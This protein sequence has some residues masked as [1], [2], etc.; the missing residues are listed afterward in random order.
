[1]DDLNVILAATGIIVNTVGLAF[2]AVQVALARRQISES[3]KIASNEHSRLRRQGTV[4]FYMATV[5]HRSRWRAILPEDWN[6]QAITVFLADAFEPG[7]QAK[8]DALTDYFGYLEGLAVAVAAG[9]YDLDT[10]DAVFGDR[11]MAVARNYRPF[12]EESRLRRG[13][14]ALYVEFEWLADK[15]RTLR[16]G[17][18][19]YVLYADRPHQAEPSATRTQLTT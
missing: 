14:P 9:V 11:L 8:L 15:L 4:D 6:Q 2:V 19:E 3:Q 12:F 17:D 10:V 16:A 13:V 7:N 1:M 18:D 5:E